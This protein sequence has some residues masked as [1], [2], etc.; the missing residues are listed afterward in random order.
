MNSASEILC[1]SCRA[2]VPADAYF[3][4]QCGKNLRARPPSISLAQQLIVYAVSLLL[5]PF[6]LWYVWKY[7]KQPDKKSKRVG[8]AAL[9]LTVMSLAAT[10]WIT[11]ALLNSVNQSLNTLNQLNF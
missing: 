4:P 5:P 3:C 11:E 6:G 9:T 1:P 8:I 10:I 7:L 2:A